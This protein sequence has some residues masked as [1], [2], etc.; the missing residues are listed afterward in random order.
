MLGAFLCLYHIGGLLGLSK[1]LRL[2]ALFLLAVMPLGIFFSRNLQAESGAFFFMC[3]G[4]LFGLRFIQTNKRSCLILFS[5]ALAVT[6]AYKMAFLIGFLPIFLLVPF[7]KYASNRKAIAIELAFLIIPLSA[8]IL[9]CYV[10]GQTSFSSTGG[11]V[12]LLRPFTAGYWRQYWP[13]IRH[14]LVN[15]NFTLTYSL[16]SA[17]G[18]LLAWV[19]LK[20]DHSLFARY[21]RAWSIMIIPYIAI[22]NDY[23]NQHNY[24]QMPFLGLVVFACI[25]FIDVC[26]RITASI[27]HTSRSREIFV[28]FFAAIFI[29]SVSGI[30]SAVRGH[31]QTIFP[32]GD[33][34]GRYL[35]GV[36]KPDE[37]FFIY[38]TSQGYAPCVYAGKGCGWP[39]SIEDFRRIEGLEH[40][41]YV[42][43]YPMA[44]FKTMPKDIKDYILGSYCI[45]SMG[46]IRTEEGLLPLSIVLKKG[47]RVDLD[48]FMRDHMS[49]AKLAA[50]YKTIGGNVTF[51]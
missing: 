12:M 40:I 1:L 21:I 18:I 30:I 6:A 35:G 44:L 17:G 20:E 47:G 5:L 11:R 43:V 14:Y 24:Y 27:L 48:A 23:I 38:T 29:L 34:I 42:V 50:V 49:D 9:Y 16:L 25:Y 19:S 2:S 15:E 33:V 28:A 36:M 8:Y 32:G 26:I 31:F 3:A 45:D 51:L 4:N 13:I 41:R 37:K 46:F 10:T 22:F 39:G 7:S